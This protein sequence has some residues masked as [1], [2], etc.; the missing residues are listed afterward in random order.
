MVKN[1]LGADAKWRYT[2]PHGK[3]NRF[4]WSEWNQKNKNHVVIDEF[5]IENYSQADLNLLQSGELLVTDQKFRNKCLIFYNRIYQEI[6]VL[7]YLYWA[8]LILILIKRV[9]VQNWTI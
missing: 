3:D 5:K 9:N 7:V 2:P 6:V 1:C 8:I 4:M